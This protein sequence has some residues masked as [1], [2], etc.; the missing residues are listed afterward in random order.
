MNPQDGLDDAERQRLV[1]LALAGWS[2]AADARV[3]SIVVGSSQVGV[4]LLVNGDYKYSIN[5]IRSENGQWDESGSSNAHW[6]RYDMDALD[7]EL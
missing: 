2:E 1:R 5:F 4:N 6:S 3:D 7:R